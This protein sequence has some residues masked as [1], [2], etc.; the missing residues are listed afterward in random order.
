MSAKNSGGGRTIQIRARSI[1]T[2]AADHPIG[3]PPPFSAH[4]ES[5]GAFEATWHLIQ[6]V[7]GLP[8][9]RAFPPLSEAAPPEAL[10][11]LRRYTYAAAE[12]A[13][14]AFLAHPT[15]VTVNVLDDGVEEQIE[16]SFPPR[17]NVR[18]FSV[19]FRQFYSDE[20]AASFKKVQSTL[21]LLNQQ[22]ADSS[23]DIRRDF[24]RSWGRAAGRLSRL[25]AEALG[26]QAAGRIGEDRPRSARQ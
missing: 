23:V 8:D 21:G 19:L 22:A 1:E 6:F 18:G 2:L 16:R 15:G 10:A 7:F 4:S 3:F 26:R 11:V 20:E 17:E 9:P 14:S 13:E 24:L 5:P 25:F 12:L